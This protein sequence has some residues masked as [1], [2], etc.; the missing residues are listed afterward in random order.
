MLQHSLDEVH[1]A[2]D[3]APPPLSSASDAADVLARF[4]FIDDDEDDNAHVHGESCTCQL[5]GC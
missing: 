2:A 1:T 4:V 5:R 3:S